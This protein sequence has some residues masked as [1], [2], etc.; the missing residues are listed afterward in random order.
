MDRINQIL[1]HPLF[2]S[3]MKENAVWEKDRVFCRHNMAHVLDVARIAYV[4]NLEDAYHLSKDMIYGAALLHD[5]GRHVQ[6]ETGEKHAYVSARLA[7][8]I[9][10][11]CGYDESE[12]AELVEAIY[13]HSDKSLMVGRDLKG[14]IARADRLSRACFACPAEAECNWDKARKNHVIEW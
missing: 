6:Y 10:R 5:I 12:C 9:L 4:L 1:Q 8:E 7:P 11:D 13:H 3:Y 14:L 2:Q